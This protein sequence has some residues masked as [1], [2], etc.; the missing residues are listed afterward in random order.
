MCF[1][2]KTGEQIPACLI[3]QSVPGLDGAQL[4]PGMLPLAPRITQRIPCSGQRSQQPCKS[5]SGSTL[6]CPSYR[7]NE[8]LL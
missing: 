3:L 7:E 6:T 5:A 2:H 4:L 8:V 1:Q